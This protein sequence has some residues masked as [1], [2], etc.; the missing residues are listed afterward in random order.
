[1]FKCSEDREW[2][3]AKYM[4]KAKAA[5]SPEKQPT[6]EEVAAYIDECDKLNKHVTYPLA[7]GKWNQLEWHAQ[8]EFD[9]TTKKA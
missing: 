3:I 6:Y 9:K 4:S 5:Y 7:G 1:M 2:K 8:Y